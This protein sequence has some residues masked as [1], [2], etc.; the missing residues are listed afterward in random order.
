MKIF[1]FFANFGIDDFLVL[2]HISLL[3]RKKKRLLEEN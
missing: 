3:N 1:G 2:L